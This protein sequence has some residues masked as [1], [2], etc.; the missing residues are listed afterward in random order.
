M[1]LF[2]CPLVINI[3]LLCSKVIIHPPDQMADW[4]QQTHI[5][6]DNSVV[7]IKVFPEVIEHSKALESLPP[8]RRGCYIKGEKQL[9][10]Y[11]VY[12][13]HNCEL[14]CKA[15]I[16]IRDCGCVPFFLPS[17]NWVVFLGGYLFYF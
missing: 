10:F 14:E 3:H 2:S 12:N 11:Q 8:S 6:Q 7:L 4:H 9:R 16:S 17:K 1:S 13:K 15:N 5:V